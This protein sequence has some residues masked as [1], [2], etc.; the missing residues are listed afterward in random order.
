MAAKQRLVVCLDGT[1]NTRDDNT[2]VLHHFA[3]VTEGSVPDGNGGSIIQRK[4]YIQGVGTGA[5]DHITGGGFGIGLEQNVRE[6][7][8]WLVQNFNDGPAGGEPDEIYIFGFSRGA[9]TARSLVGFIGSCG[10]LKRGA[11]ITVNQ[12]WQNHCVLGRLREERSSIWDLVF[13]ESEPAC[14]PMNRLVRDSWAEFSFTPPALNASER[15]LVAWSRRVRITYLGVYD[16]VGAMG[17]DALAIPGLRSKVAMHHNLRPTSLIRRCRHALAMNEHRI[18]FNHNPFVQYVGHPS[19]SHP[20]SETDHFGANREKWRERIEQ[21]WFVGAHSNVGGGYP[22]NELAQIPFRWLFAGAA[23][24]ETP[25][26]ENKPR[27]LV[28]ES[29]PNFTSSDCPPIRDSYEEFAHPFWSMILRGKR[30]YRRLSPTPEFRATRARANNEGGD[31]K[32]SNIRSGFSLESINETVDGSVY[33]YWRKTNGDLPPNLVDFAQRQLGENKDHP[34]ANHLAEILRKYP[35]HAWLGN[36]LAAYA[37]LIIWS[38]LAAA[39]VETMNVLI[40]SAH[41]AAVPVLGLCVAAFLLPMVDWLESRATFQIALKPFTPF[42]RALADSVYW[43]RSLG[44]ILFVAGA[45]ASIGW[46]WSLGKVASVSDQPLHQLGYNIANAFRYWWPLPLAAAAGL[47]V[48]AKFEKHTQERARKVYGGLAVGIMVSCAILAAIPVVGWVGGRIFSPIMNISTQFEIEPPRDAEFAGLLIFLELALLYLFR[49][50]AWVEEPLARAHLG[51]IIPLQFCP[52]P[53]RVMLRLER[54]RKMLTPLHPASRRAGYN[55][56]QSQAL[57]D[58]LEQALIRDLI[59]LIPVYAFVI[60]LAIRFA[61]RQLH[62]PWAHGKIYGLPFWFILPLIPAI[63]DA[64]EDFIHLRYLKYHEAGKLP[65]WYLPRISVLMTILKTVS[66]WPLLGLTMWTA[67]TAI[68]Q[69]ARDNAQS[70]WRGAVALLIPSL[71]V[72]ALLT[73][74]AGVLLYRIRYPKKKLPQGSSGEYEDAPA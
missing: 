68:Y 16:T 40:H 51:S 62:A 36:S 39:G 11:P 74:V 8:N 70:G 64:V 26:G 3:F 43:T 67:C 13:P 58:I 72:G 28:C 19:E 38:C 27:G 33:D 29:L 65:P 30:H 59:G 49:A 57:R 6:A 60:G 15:L 48:T 22:D 25:P 45:I 61:D 47:L 18:S 71:F 1:W 37:F 73:L 69:L 63:F 53:Q 14:R 7:Y 34:D 41:Q 20:I 23:I 31:G 44:F 5:L 17:L 2:N 54:W 9:Y 52:T 10:L 24:A 56:P 55:S 35:Q 46:L 42:Y 12:L 66:F 32:R 4:E 50:L 21:R